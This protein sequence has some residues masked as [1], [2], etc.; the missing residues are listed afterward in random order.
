MNFENS[1][2]FAQELDLRDP[3]KSYRDLFHIP[4]VNGRPALYFTGNSLGLQPKTARSF[5]EQEMKDWEMYAVEGHFKDSKR[6]WMYYHKFL[7]DSLAKLVG[8]KPI[9]V[10][11]MNQLTVNLHLLM[12]SFYRPTERRFKIIA[13]AGAFPSDQYMFETQI[14]H[15]GLN[16]DD[17]LIELKPRQGEHN[18]RTEDILKT[19]AETGDELALV[20]LS[21]VQYYTGQLFDIKSI[22]KKG[23]EVGAKVGWDLA[24]AM[25]NVPLSLHDWGVDFATW[26]SYK[27]LNSGPGNVSGVFVHERYAHDSN[28]PRFAGWWGQEEST[29]FQMTKGFKPMTGADGWQ[30]S[31]VNVL[32]SAAHLASLEIFDKVGVNALREKSLLLTGYMEFLI[33]ELSGE[34]NIF[35]IITPKDP[36]S[37]GCQLSIFCHKNGKM[38]F[39]ALSSEGV[40][41]DWREPNVIRVAPVPL[42]NTFEDV[43][44]FARILKE[45]IQKM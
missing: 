42:Y 22:T 40:I 36:E 33:N 23:Q 32:S 34:E 28:L 41:S 21:G 18:L 11:S 19:I 14:K 39:D 16:P 3:L 15:H 5:I 25:G 2:S 26:C 1:L 17:T 37:R 10:V 35:E 38:L 8:A 24:H 30:L 4:K 13:E 44:H 7:K 29:R 6:P 12:V 43:Y 31:N 9:E 27:Y 45:H 20:L